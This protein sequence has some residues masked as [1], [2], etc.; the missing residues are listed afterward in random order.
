MAIIDIYLPELGESVSRATL[1]TWMKS[2]GDVV[3]ENEILIRVETEKV[4]L[5]VL[6]PSSGV[7]AEV[8]RGDGSVVGSGEVIARIDN[9]DRAVLPKPAADGGAPGGDARH[10]LPD[11]GSVSAASPVS[12]KTLA[13]IGAAAAVIAGPMAPTMSKKNSH[14]PAGL[15]FEA[16]KNAVEAAEWLEL[17]VNWALYKNTPFPS[18]LVECCPSEVAEILATILAKQ[19]RV[20]VRFL[21]HFAFQISKLPRALST[22]SINSVLYLDGLDQACA[23]PGN[24]LEICNALNET[25]NSVSIIASVSNIEELPAGVLELFKR[26]LRVA[27]QTMVSNNGIEIPMGNSYEQ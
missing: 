11:L 22:L 16:L 27:P 12:A 13:N 21:K 7:F 26:S 3:S 20:E 25:S 14:E 15:W 8:V 6:A 1:L 17:D 24:A 23:D 10:K 4:V 5:D 2:R 19:R 18:I 9:E